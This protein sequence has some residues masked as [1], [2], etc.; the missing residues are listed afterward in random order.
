VCADL[1]HRGFEVFRAVSPSCSADIIAQKNDQLYRIEI[2]TARIS[3][4]GK[5]TYA[6]PVNTTKYDV[7]ALV[8]PDNK[9]EI[10]YIPSNFDVM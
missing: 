6:K 2:K 10:M 9:N 1:L 8:F 4:K 7:L 5:I 3:H